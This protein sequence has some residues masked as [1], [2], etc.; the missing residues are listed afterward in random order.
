M[1]WH[2]GTGNILWPH[3]Q[4]IIVTVQFYFYCDNCGEIYCSVSILLFHY[5]RLAEGGNYILDIK[6]PLMFSFQFCSL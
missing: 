1:S 6:M 5:A 2:A 4:K 3:L